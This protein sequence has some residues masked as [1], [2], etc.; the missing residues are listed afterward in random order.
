MTRPPEE[1]VGDK[2]RPAGTARP[3]GDSLMEGVELG[4]QS[5]LVRGVSGGLRL[6]GRERGGRGHDPSGA[7]VGP[8]GPKPK[9]VWSKAVFWPFLR[10]CLRHDAFLTVRRALVTGVCFLL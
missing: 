3:V 5:A 4:A 9:G 7:A 6:R 1:A 2:G 8:A 10:Q